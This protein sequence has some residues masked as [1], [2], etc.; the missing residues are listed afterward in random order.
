VPA[1]AR[2]VAKGS[3]LFFYLAKI[4]WFAAQPSSLIVIAMI[5][6]V[7][8][9]RTSWQRL[10]RWLLIGGLAALVVLGLSPISAALIV[11]L[12]NRFPRA[13]LDRG[14][15]I[16]GIIVL[17]G[18]EDGRADPPRELAGLNEAAERIT[19]AVALSRRYPQAR[20]VFTGGSGAL[21]AD[22]APES[23]AMGR[24]LEALGVPR[25]RLTLESRSRDT[26]EN[27]A[28]TKRLINPAPGER[29]LLITSGWH[30]PRAIGCFRKAGFPVEPWTV[31]YRTSGRIDL[32]PNPNLTVGLRQIDFTTREYIGLLMYYLSG[33]TSALFP[34]P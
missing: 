19:E 34:A 28:F 5:A 30:M 13:D 1:H 20:I 12:E 24:L 16:I 6:G 3:S 8:L 10:G 26:Y 32:W 27:A 15:P 9:L 21:V 18:A 11:P 23:V 7:I 2:S 29:W 4:V 31:D 17:G 25:D 33:R 22:S 14:P